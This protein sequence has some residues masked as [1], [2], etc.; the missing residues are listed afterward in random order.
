MTNNIDKYTN[1]IKQSSKKNTKF[2]FRLTNNVNFFNGLAVFL[3]IVIFIW[4]FT[5]LL[6][7]PNSN[8][9][10][11]FLDVSSFY[12]AKISVLTNSYSLSLTV[13]GIIFIIAMI[14]FICFTIFCILNSKKHI[15]QLKP[16]KYRYISVYGL[17]FYSVIFLLFF[18]FV[19]IPPNVSAVANI[20]YKTNII[21]NATQSADLQTILNAYKTLGI[22][23]PEY[24]NINELANN[25]T[26]YIPS[27]VINYS[28][29][30]TSSNG[31]V[32]FQASIIAIYTL[33][34]IAIFTILFIFIFKFVYV[35]KSYIAPSVTKENMK[36]ILEA[37]KQNKKEKKELKK[38]KKRLLDEENKLLQNLYE[39]DVPN[40]EENMK[41]QVAISQAELEEKVNKNNEL[42]KQLED[43]VKQ[44]EELKKESLKKSKFKSFI[45]KLQENNN[46]KS[47]HKKQEIAVPDQELEEIF[48]SLDIE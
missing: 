41:K 38:S 27:N 35:N 15:K 19:L 29:F 25:L 6:I 40:N 9:S 44:K 5:M 21:N 47:K 2:K 10:T 37:Y 11:S 18:I 42:K 24:N 1:V 46:S 48:R 31:F 34:A 14:C 4:M 13:N 26:N 22:A 23:L 28:I 39:I 8:L 30:S 7:M 36:L 33:F 20:A 45:N 12:S 43:L 17:I 32:E 3:S 16:Y